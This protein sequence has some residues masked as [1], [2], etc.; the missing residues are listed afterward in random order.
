MI[1]RATTRIA[2]TRV[3]VIQQKLN[4]SPL[5]F[6]CL[7]VLLLADHNTDLQM[8]RVATLKEPVENT[9]CSAGQNGRERGADCYRG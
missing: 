7:V 2:L 6:L 3:V 5:G 1:I 4:L 8:A 9:F